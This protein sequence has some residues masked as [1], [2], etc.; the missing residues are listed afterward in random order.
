[1]SKIWAFI[2]NY[3]KIVFFV[4]L[5]VIGVIFLRKKHSDLLDEIEDLRDDHKEELEKIDIER[6]K[7][8]K[9]HKENEERLKVALDA[10]RSQYEEAKLELTYKKEKEIQK[11][12]KQYGKNP[13][14]LAKQLSDA[15]GF[16]VILPE[17]DQHEE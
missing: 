5:G 6:E 17:P 12:V 15:T 4:I 3:S 7:E 2:K 10:I 14:E 8:R 11:I 1:M 16:K 13:D 9:A